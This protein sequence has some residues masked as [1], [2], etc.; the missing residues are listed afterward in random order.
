MVTLGFS[1]WACQDL[2]DGIVDG[3]LNDETR[4]L[5]VPLDD[6]WLEIE[7]VVLDTILVVTDEGGTTVDLIVKPLDGATE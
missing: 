1:I 6:V 7:D 3:V 2:P 5:F 4:V